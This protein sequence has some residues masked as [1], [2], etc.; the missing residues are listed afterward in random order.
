MRRWIAFILAAVMTLSFTACGGENSTSA[1]G[2][3]SAADSSTSSGA[4]TED[5]TIQLNE[6][7]TTDKFE[8]TLT[9]AEF[10]GKSSE[11]ADNYVVEIMD[12]DKE[13]LRCDYTLSY[14][15]KESLSSSP[16]AM[17]VQYGDGYTFEDGRQYLVSPD[18]EMKETYRYYDN[19]STNMSINFEPLTEDVYTGY[20]FVEVPETAKDSTE[21]KLCISILISGEEFL[22]EMR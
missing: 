16:V 4:Q 18:G 3:N 2:E 7:V 17:T 15:G 19:S 22:Y 10:V 13:L 5:K 12:S 11:I 6:T 21:E 1:K 9:N 20:G 14:I 8:F